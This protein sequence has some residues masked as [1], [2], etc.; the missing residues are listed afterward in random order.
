MSGNHDTILQRN[1]GLCLPFTAIDAPLPTTNGVVLDLEKGLRNWGDKA[2]YHKYLLKFAAYHGKDGD[3]IGQLLAEGDKH[4]ARALAHKLKGVAGNLAMMAVANQAGNIEHILTNGSDTGNEPEAL[5]LAL[6]S[7]VQEITSV[8]EGE[9]CSHAPPK[10]V[11]DAASLELSLRDL[12]QA[13]DK[14]NP[15]VVEPLLLELEKVMPSE[16][17]Q[18]IREQVDNFNFRAAEQLTKAFI[19]PPVAL[20][21]E[22]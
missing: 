21:M 10:R 11:V 3:T 16:Q 4:H 22:D 14:D 17:L 9:Q 20:P 2:V 1:G 12:L 8:T 13:L 15:D 19:A 6:D 7:A 5:Q 18:L